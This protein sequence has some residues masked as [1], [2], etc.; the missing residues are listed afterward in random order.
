MPWK[1]STRLLDSIRANLIRGGAGSQHRSRW[2]LWGQHY[3]GAPS[4]SQGWS[5]ATSKHCP[6]PPSDDTVTVRRMIIKIVFKPIKP[7]NLYSCC[8]QTNSSWEKRSLENK[9]IFTTP[10]TS[11]AERRK[12]QVI[13]EKIKIKRVDQFKNVNVQIAAN[14]HIKQARILHSERHSIHY[15]ARLKELSKM[16]WIKFI[17]VENFPPARAPRPT[18]VRL[19]SILFLLH[20]QD[21]LGRWWVQEV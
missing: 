8:Q 12:N 14:F 10:L 21:N 3:C 6:S 2:C 15:Y 20:F 4:Y 13:L 11:G 7:Y 17:T 16:F 5:Q 19:R 1:A 9:T 18:P